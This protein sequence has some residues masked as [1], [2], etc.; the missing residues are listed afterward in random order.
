MKRIC[1]FCGSKQG[2]RVEYVDAA[3]ALGDE[4]ARRGIGL[5]YGGGQIGLMGRIAD[6]VLS[7]GGEVIGVIPRKL[8]EKEVAHT[9]LSKLEVVGDMHERKALMARLSDGFI[10]MPGGLGTFEELFEVTAWA[11]LGFH[12]KPCAI[13]NVRGYYD[14]LGG[15]LQQAV[16]EGFVKAPDIDAIIIDTDAAQLLTKMRAFLDGNH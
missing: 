11:A 10:T 1:V 8:L 2:K 7:Q 6:R 15:V 5:V 3:N 4:L 13:L 16:D 12:Q 14:A 9:R